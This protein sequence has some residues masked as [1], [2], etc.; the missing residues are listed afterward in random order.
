MDLLI[1]GSAN[2]FCVVIIIVQYRILW[3]K[4]LKTMLYLQSY[5]SSILPFSDQHVPQVSPCMR[6]HKQNFVDPLLNHKSLSAVIIM[7]HSVLKSQGLSIGS[8]S[9][10]REALFT[11]Q[12]YTFYYLH[13]WNLSLCNSGE[14]HFNFSAHF[15]SSFTTQFGCRKEC[16]LTPWFWSRT[17]Y[18]YG[19]LQICYWNGSQDI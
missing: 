6:F 7:F 17:S 5:F 19:R 11:S 3:P 13:V 8:S 16:I 9:K 12:I 10:E 2:Y 1:G 15:H 4:K 14:H 18:W